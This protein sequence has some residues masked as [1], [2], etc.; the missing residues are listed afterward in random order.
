MEYVYIANTKEREI[1]FG[2]SIP[3]R[4]KEKCIDTDPWWNVHLIVSKDYGGKKID[5]SFVAES[6]TTTELDALVHEI[7]NVCLGDQKE[8]MMFDT[9]EPDYR[10]EFDGT[11]G[12]LSI[13]LAYADSLKLWLTK[14]NFISIKEYI[15]KALVEAN[16]RSVM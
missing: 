6:M 15:K 11:S 12:I 7:E 13:N 1:K 2:L 4:Y 3:E 16:F 5:F 8:K 14:D 10:F 9:I